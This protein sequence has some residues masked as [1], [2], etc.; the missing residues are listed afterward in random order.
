MWQQFG[1]VIL[2]LIIALWT[3]PN[4]ITLSDHTPSAVEKEKLAHK[5]LKSAN[6]ILERRETAGLSPLYDEDTPT[7][8]KMPISGI[9]ASCIIVRL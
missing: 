5:V 6:I 3:T 8:T 2:L 4:I 7:W 9:P 1:F